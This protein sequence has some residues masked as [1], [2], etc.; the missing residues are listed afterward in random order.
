MKDL[1]AMFICFLSLV[2]FTPLWW[3]G[4]G[5]EFTDRAA[6]TPPS[7]QV[8]TIKWKCWGS[9]MGT[10]KHSSVSSCSVPSTDACPAF[11][12]PEFP[13]KGTVN[14]SAVG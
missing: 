5:P 4:L 6:A 11:P 10:L 9:Q 2:L 1:M 8:R 7:F 3:Q 13:S 12:H 14:L